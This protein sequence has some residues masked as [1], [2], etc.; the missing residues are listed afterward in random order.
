MSIADSPVVTQQYATSQR[1]ETR[2]SIHEKYSR[3]KQPFGEWIASHYDLRPGEQVL[4]LGCGTGSMWRGVSLPQ[5]CHV[6][7]TDLSPG[8]L[9]KARSSTGHLHADYAICNAMSLPYGDSSFDVVIANMMLYH[10]PDIP[11]AL[12]EI[13]RVLKPGGR[14]YAATFGVHGAV[15]AVL[16]ILGLPC[17]VNHRFTLQNGQDMLG[18]FFSQVNLICRDDA[19]DVTHLPDLIDYLHSMT[20]MTVLADIPDKQLMEVFSSHMKNGVLSLPKEYGLFICK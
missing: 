4:E 2:I 17:T 1:L 5:G 16:D 9:E 14:F 6:T 20:G 12:R 3:N 10:V 13:H 7:L 8:M 11:G 18:Q 19:L 15:E